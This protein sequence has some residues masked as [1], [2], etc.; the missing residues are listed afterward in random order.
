MPRTT[1]VHENCGTCTECAQ[2]PQIIKYKCKKGGS[3]ELIKGYVCEGKDCRGEQKTSILPTIIKCVMIGQ[4]A[5]LV[6][7]AFTGDVTI[8]AFVCFVAS[9]LCL[10]IG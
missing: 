8:G 1:P 10:F 3:Y 4:V 2:N 5:G 7:F 9:I 6:A